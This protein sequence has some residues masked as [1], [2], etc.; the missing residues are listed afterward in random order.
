M[1]D[2]S[3]AP[4]RTRTALEQW[5]AALPAEC[6]SVM[7][8]GGRQKNPEA[9]EYTADQ[10]AGA[11]SFLRHRNAGGANVYIRPVSTRHI[12]I[13]DLDEDSLGLVT[14]HH[15]VAAIVET[16]PWCWQ[17]WISIAAEVLDP[18]LASAVARLLARRFGGDLGAA[19][20][21]QHGRAPGLTN[22][23]PR[24]ER[25]DGTYPWARLQHA[26]LVVDSAGEELLRDAAAAPHRAR[27]RGYGSTADPLP[28]M[29]RTAGEEYQA[30]AQAVRAVLS[31]GVAVDRSRL[32]YAAARRLVRRGASM[33]QAEAV[34][35]AGSKAAGMRPG[36]AAAYARRTVEAVLRDLRA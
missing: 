7:I 17:A 36:A 35:L 19:S 3:V 15:E 23:K 33:A 34:V 5:C 32:D 6:Y 20:A 16:S 11:A 26:G 22:R 13:D 1:K 8:V 10:L 24:H 14:A 30:A 28:S 2:R 12:L 31:P 27:V 25:A 9:R 18:G 4:C 29:S 21:F